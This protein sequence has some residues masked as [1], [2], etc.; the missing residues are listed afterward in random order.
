M[1]LF[2]DS[3]KKCENRKRRICR[4]NSIARG[5]DACSL[6]LKSKWGECIK[7]GIN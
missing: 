5:S 6:V 4:K 1:G 2:P 3:C 7:R